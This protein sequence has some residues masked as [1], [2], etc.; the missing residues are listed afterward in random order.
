MRWHGS[1]IIRLIAIIVGLGTGGWEKFV[2]GVGWIPA[3]T[4]TILIILAIPVITG[5]VWEAA[6]R[7]MAWREINIHSGAL[8]G[9]APLDTG[10]RTLTPARR[11][12]RPWRVVEMAGGYAVEDADGQQLGMFYGSRAAPDVARQAQTLTMDEA[13]RMA[14]NFARL[15]EL[16]SVAKGAGRS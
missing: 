15:P 3:L 11:F 2:L 6:G 8:D 16:L 1:G 4:L 12:P 7:L 9:L 5:L 10:H 13:R 14:A